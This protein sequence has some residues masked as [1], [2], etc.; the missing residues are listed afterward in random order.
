MGFGE[1]WRAKGERFLCGEAAKKKHT[2]GRGAVWEQVRF[3]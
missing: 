3:P 1:G 2:E